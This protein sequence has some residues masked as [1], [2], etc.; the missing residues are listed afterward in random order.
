MNL[1]YTVA[2]VSM[3]GG[4]LVLLMHSLRIGQDVIGYIDNI[5][6]TYFMFREG[7]R[8]DDFLRIIFGL[9]GLPVGIL[10]FVSFLGA[11]GLL[12]GAA[13]IF[14]NDEA[15]LDI[16]FWSSVL[17]V[18]GPVYAILYGAA[19]VTIPFVIAYFA[20]DEKP[21][22]VYL[23][24][25]YGFGAWELFCFLFVPALS[26]YGVNEVYRREG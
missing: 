13:V 20:A 5:K 14:I 2:I 24:V 21:D 9:F 25:L 10:G 11:A 16:V 23:L 18:V 12:I 6:L 8:N 22:F 26:L 1:K 4:L 17:L 3:I 7:T 15:G 19:L